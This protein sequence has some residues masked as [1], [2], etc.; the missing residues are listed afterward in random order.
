MSSFQQGRQARGRLVSNVS[1]L[2][3]LILENKKNNVIELYV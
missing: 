2:F 3:Y 1:E